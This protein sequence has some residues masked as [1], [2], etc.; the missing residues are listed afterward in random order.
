MQI[1]ELFR[2]KKVLFSFEFFPPKNAEGEKELFQ[3]IDNLRS[4]KPAFVSV[5]YGAM[6]GQQDRTL[7]LVKKVHRELGIVVMAHFTCIGAEEARVDSFLK[8]LKEAGIENILALRGDIPEG[9]SPEEALKGPYRYADQLVKAIRTKTDNFTVAVAGYPNVHIEAKDLAADLQAL[10]RKV[11]AGG[12][13]VITQF[14]FNN[15]DFYRFRDKARARGITVPIIPGIMPIQ[16]IKQIEIF[17]KKCGVPVPDNIQNY[18]NDTRYNDQDRKQFGI[19]LASK[20][21]CD[22]LR[23][24]VPGIHFYTLNKSKATREICAQLKR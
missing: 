12:D 14:F 15:E 17:S 11:D 6:G 2:S 19:D 8:E 7:F 23:Q 24:G 4:L 22:L 16:N 10:K 20:Q 3:T 21:C 18:F 9:V 1:K 5:T 13:F